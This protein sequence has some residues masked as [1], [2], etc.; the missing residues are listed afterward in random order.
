M[1]IAI[2]EHDE[3]FINFMLNTVEEWA[4]SRSCSGVHVRVFVSV[5]AFWEAMESG[6][7]FDLMF[8]DADFPG[9]SGFTLAKKIRERDLNIP[10]VLVASGDLYAVQGY[11]LSLYRYLQKPVLP[12]Q[13]HACLD[14]GLQYARAAAQ[15]SFLI[16]R[17]G[18]AQRLPY[19]DVLYCASGIH[20][21]TIYT[22]QEREYTFPLKT[23]FER[24]VSAF[25]AHQFIRCHRGYIVNLS[26]VIKY[27]YRELVLS[28]NV[29]LP[30]GR[31][32]SE[33]VLARLREYLGSDTPI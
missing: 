33:Q 32:Y 21:I 12:E 24:Y 29:H 15:E 23:T 26:H 14:H 4:Q 18:F 22:V 9:L 1:E 27:T 20:N 7:A 16:V 25:P 13:I 8:L 2:Y 3:A 28:G 6:K 10:L 30:I 11:E 17:K 5:E 31:T 19:R